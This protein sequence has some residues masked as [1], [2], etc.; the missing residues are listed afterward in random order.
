MDL[1][2]VRGC[3]IFK[4]VL[5]FEWG[6]VLVFSEGVSYYFVDYLDFLAEVLVFRLLYVFL[7]RD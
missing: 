6:E 2:V 1:V 7:G 5:V 4:E 3:N